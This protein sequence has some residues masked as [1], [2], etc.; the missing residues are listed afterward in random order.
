MNVTEK[1]EELVGR[2]KSPHLLKEGGATKCSGNNQR[3]C[4]HQLMVLVCFVRETFH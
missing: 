3:S 4:T 2:T 1:M